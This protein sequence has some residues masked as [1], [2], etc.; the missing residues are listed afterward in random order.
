MRSQVS[1]CWLSISKNLPNMAERKV[2]EW[3]QSW[4]DRLSKCKPPGEGNINNRASFA[5]SGYWN[6]AYLIFTLQGFWISVCLWWKYFF[7]IQAIPPQKS[8]RPAGIFTQPS[9]PCPDYYLCLRGEAKILAQSPPPRS[10]IPLSSC[11]Q[12][13][14]LCHTQGLLCLQLDNRQWPPQTLPLTL[15]DKR[16]LNKGALVT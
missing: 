10:S 2:E 15:G 6:K 7:H 11:S 5:S 8:L 16:F 1:N 14:F 12:K 9:G 4:T 3:P 13:V